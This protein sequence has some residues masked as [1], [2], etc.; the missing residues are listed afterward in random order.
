M[1]AHT[2]HTSPLTCRLAS[3]PRDLEEV[4]RI[5]HECYV[6]TG[7]IEPREGGLFSDAYDALPNHFSFLVDS[8]GEGPIATIR[9]S[10]LSPRLGWTRVPAAT[11]FGDHPA[12]QQMAG[13]SLVEANRLCFRRQARRDIFYRLGA[14]LAALADCHEAR[15]IVACP[16]VEHSPTYRRVFGMHRLGEPRKYFGVN[17]ETELLGLRREELRATANR[18][19][20]MKAAWAEASERTTG[21]IPE[22]GFAAH[23]A[24][25]GTYRYCPSAC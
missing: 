12:F 3:S 24:G 14:H 5:R 6:R 15:W 7:A 9:I 22:A 21:R 18:T 25:R 10:V 11:V 13:E 1:I 17:F 20:K 19:E 2:V 23:A 16:R 8:P 4:F